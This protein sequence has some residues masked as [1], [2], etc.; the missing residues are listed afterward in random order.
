MTSF[1]NSKLIVEEDARSL[2][3]SYANQ[4]STRLDSKF[5]T[6]EFIGN[7]LLINKSSKDVVDKEIVNFVSYLVK[8]YP[9]TPA[10]SIYS[11]DNKI[12][13]TTLP[14]I[15]NVP[16]I[17]FFP[18]NKNPNY[19]LGLVHIGYFHNEVL[20]ERY[21]LRDS[22]GKPIYFIRTVYFLKN[23]LSSNIKDQDF[24]FIVIDLRNNTQLGSLYNG[25]VT[26][27]LSNINGNEIIVGVP[28]YPFEIKA[29]YPQEL[30]W[31]TYINTSLKRW[32]LEGFILIFILLLNIY[33]LFYIN[34]REREKRNLQRII[35]FGSVLSQVNQ[36]VAN[37][38]DESV[39]Y[40]SICDIAIEFG[41]LKLSFIARPDEN[42]VFRI[43]AASGET[44][45]AHSV[46]ISSNPNIPEG[47]GSSG[48]TWRE[49]AP[50]Y[51]QSFEKELF[52][53]PWRDLA[54]KSGI[55][56]SAT[57]P[58]FRNNDIWANF[59]VYHAN[60]NVFTGDL[61]NLLE[62]L[63]RDIS[64]GLDRLDYRKREKETSEIRKSIIENALVGIALV[65]DRTF[66][67]V[68]PKYA[69]IFGYADPQDL[70]GK[71]TK[72]LFYDDEE[73]E[74]V[75]K[76]Y[77][78]LLMNKKTELMEIRQ[79]G[80]NNKQIICE[81]TANV[82]DEDEKIAIWTVQDITEKKTYLEKLRQ[83]EQDYRKLFEDHSAVKLLIDPENGDIFDANY[84]AANY[85]GYDR[86]DLIKMN[87]S[88][89]NALPQDEVA[90]EMAKAD[91]KDKTHFEFRHRRADGS[92]RDVEV[93]SNSIQMSGKRLLHS[94]IFDITERKRA[95]SELERAYFL[96]NNIIEN[97]PDATFVINI[98]GKVLA[99]NKSMEILTKMKKEDI[100]GK[101][102]LEYSKLFY[103][104]PQPLLIDL[105][106]N[107][108]EEFI[109]ENYKIIYRFENI[110]YAESYA[111]NIF[112]YKGAYIFIAT[113][114][115]KDRNGK[116]IGAI[117]SIR[118]ISDSKMMEEKL[119]ELSIKD[120]LT[121]SYNR[122]YF[123]ERL[124]EE[125]DRTKRNNIP[126]SLIMLDI[127]D[128][129][130]INDN[131]G[132]IVGDKVLVEIV[133]FVKNRIR[134]TDF[135][136]RWGG[137][138]FMI[139]LTNTDL[140]NAEKLA[141]ELKNGMSK[142]DIPEID[143]VTASFGVTSYHQSDTVNSITKRVDDLMYAAK[144]AGK[145]CV[146]S[147]LNDAND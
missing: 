69:Q 82:I 124:E 31:Q 65:K 137:E 147:D 33:F 141:L 80:L 144:A 109:K 97:L 131:Y 91:K 30:I 132:H 106:L 2:A 92:I 39:L 112:D 114:K 61:K 66:L 64:I 130:A 105:I 28:G 18:L 37:V 51:V 53:S 22:A 32:L 113:S 29:V 34:R 62:E 108:D 74:R 23:L 58:I 104:D 43:L 26:T 70:I 79:K 38:Q 9:E 50:N 111:P 36:L 46:F 81:A 19:Q 85:Y 44:D 98:E 118:D 59:S 139:L 120:S 117:E 101:N 103:H 140:N 73:Y 49:K 8:F 93:F 119:H 45:Y 83:S 20:N 11:G 100:L 12:I 7:L 68:N 77:N 57:I 94:I 52:T 60:K 129:K 128:F 13:F 27:N 136:A 56:S 88:D 99:W 71:P 127:D 145:N 3:S 24:H 35:D 90:K 146:K 16:E 48:R 102:Y 6:L 41:H 142:L 55:K 138:E 86:S 87:I 14:N 96:L 4:I 121:D 67:Q 47:Q 1:H 72:T 15:K 135:I 25:I 5:N 42:G 126:F 84:A 40:Q 78:D 17:N 116:T 125:I 107:A 89:L 134:K 110:I 95:Q 75:G 10:F 143:F 123:Q 21:I 63:S 115:L 122:R 54:K 133:K 76:I